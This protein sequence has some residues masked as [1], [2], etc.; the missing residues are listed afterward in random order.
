M[1]KA[2]INEALA[3]LA[4]LLNTNFASFGKTK[5]D[6]EPTWSYKYSTCTVIVRLA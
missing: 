2:L 5:K 4:S 6:G 3:Q 1:Y